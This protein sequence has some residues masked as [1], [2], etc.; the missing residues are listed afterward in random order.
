MKALSIQQPWAGLIIT[1]WKDCENRTWT[2]KYRGPLAICASKIMYEDA[3]SAATK[4]VRGLGKKIDTRG[5]AAYRR[6]VIVGWVYLADIVT[7]SDS[8]WFAGPYGWILRDPHAIQPI[9]FS[10][11]LGLFDVDLETIHE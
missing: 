1:G 8:V 7:E 9:P 5:M 4:I 2:T 11:R 10:G 3:V 6:G